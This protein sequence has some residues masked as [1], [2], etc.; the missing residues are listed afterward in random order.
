[1][2][3]TE[4]NKWEYQIGLLKCLL[5]YHERVTAPVGQEMCR[6][7][8]DGGCP[9]AHALEQYAEALREAIRCMEAV[10]RC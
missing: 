2:E 10:H 7:L 9:E 4:V 8:T 5:H 6:V 1:M 3:I